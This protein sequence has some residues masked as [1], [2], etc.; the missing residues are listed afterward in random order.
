MNYPTA[1]RP[2]MPAPLAPAPVTSLYF[3]AHITIEPVKDTNRGM[4]LYELAGVRDFR[5]ADFVMRKDKNADAFVS[6]RGT[7]YM[8]LRTKVIDMIDILVHFGFVVKRYKIENTLED[9]RFSNVPVTPNLVKFYK[10]LMSANNITQYPDLYT[11]RHNG[12]GKFPQ[13]TWDKAEQQAADCPVV[14]MDTLCDGEEQE[15]ATLIEKHQWHELDMIL[16]FMWE[17]SV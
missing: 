2:F 12:M 3:E 11:L 7:D 5:V 10:F 8:A 1:T 14:D 15:R 4:Q 16:N 17:E 13:E 6:A 9:M